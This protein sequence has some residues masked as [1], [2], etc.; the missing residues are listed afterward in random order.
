MLILNDFAVLIKLVRFKLSVYLGN[1]FESLL[2]NFLG[3]KLNFLALF[4]W[5][6]FYI[7]LDL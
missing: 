1:F 2:K 5:E 6:K 7:L 4:V 3:S